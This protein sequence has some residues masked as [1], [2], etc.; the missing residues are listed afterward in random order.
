MFRKTDVILIAA[1]MAAAAVTYHI[2][3]RAEATESQISRL[4]TQIRLEK[5]QMDVLRA[6]WSLMTQPARLQ[7]VV[8]VYKDELGLEPLQPTQVTKIDDL[9]SAPPELEPDPAKAGIGVA[10]AGRDATVTGGITR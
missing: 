4:R 6:D 8:D 2:K 7:H 3:D 9:P 1:M 5:E 10:S